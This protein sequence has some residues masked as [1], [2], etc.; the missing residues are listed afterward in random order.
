MTKYEKIYKL[1]QENPS[2][3]IKDA[4]KRQCWKWWY[5]IRAEI[6]MFWFDLKDKLKFKL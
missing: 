4:Q 6:L 2:N 1:A 5:N 3:W